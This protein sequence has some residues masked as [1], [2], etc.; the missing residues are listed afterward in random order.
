VQRELKLVS[1]DDVYFGN[2]RLALVRAA[3]L[4]E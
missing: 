3:L 1:G 2:D 4:H